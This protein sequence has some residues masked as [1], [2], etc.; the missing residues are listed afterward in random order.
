MNHN[1]FQFL[2][3]FKELTSIIKD[4]SKELGDFDIKL[5]EQQIELI[6]YIKNCVLMLRRY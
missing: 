1:D 3:L 4:V 6:Q 5:F 2:N